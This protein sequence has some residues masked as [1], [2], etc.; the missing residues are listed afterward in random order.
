MVK[1]NAINLD[2]TNNAVG[3]TI[4]GGTTKRNFTWNG[5]GDITLTAQNANGVFTLPNQSTDT[6]V[7]FSTWTAKGVIISASA[8]NTPSALTVGSDGTS[9]QADSTQTTGLKWVAASNVVW[10]EVTGTSQTMV[11]NNGYI[12]NNAGLVTA[13]LPASAA[14]GTII[15]VAGKGAGGWTI[16]QGTGQSIKFG[17]QATTTTTGSLSSTNQFDCVRL[18]CTVA[19]TTWT[20]LSAQGNITVV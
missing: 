2:V 15:E 9:L 1:N 8:A 5:S 19:N 18:L 13:T 7:G 10:Q 12:L 6:L 14:L 20:V 17:N 4:G 11:A 3:V 16:A